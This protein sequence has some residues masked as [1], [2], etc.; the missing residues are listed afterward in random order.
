MLI[1]GTLQG[2]V[3]HCGAPGPRISRAGGETTAGRE[4]EEGRK[5]PVLVLWFNYVLRGVL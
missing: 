3:G 4:A 1:D 5:S 2:A